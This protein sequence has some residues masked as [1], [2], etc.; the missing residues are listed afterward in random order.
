M[1]G[2]IYFRVAPG[3]GSCGLPRLACRAAL[4]GCPPT[5]ASPGSR[6]ARADAVPQPRRPVRTAP[7]TRADSE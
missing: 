3:L 2:S 5:Q 1:Y 6:P 7:V 4:P